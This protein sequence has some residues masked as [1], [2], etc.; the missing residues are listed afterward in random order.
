MSEDEN[1][2]AQ[3]YS[4]ADSASEASNS[5]SSSSSGS[6]SSDSNAQIGA[7]SEDE[8][9]YGLAQINAD[10]EAEAFAA[11]QEEAVEMLTN[12]LSQIGIDENEQLLAQ[13][14]EVMSDDQ[15]KMMAMD[16]SIYM[17][18]AQL[19]SDYHSSRNEAVENILAQ[20]GAE[21]EEDM[22]EINELLAQLDVKELEE[23]YTELAQTE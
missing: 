8:D 1:G 18:L 22:D 6:S 9:E 20:V 23:L 5:S 19:A 13:L 7:E 4:E 21:G 10:I 11:E 16:P 12:F 14:G 15:L 2:F 17:G 3:I